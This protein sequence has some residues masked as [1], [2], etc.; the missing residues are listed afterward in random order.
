MKDSKLT[1]FD[2]GRIPAAAAAACSENISWFLRFNIWLLPPKTGT[3][4]ADA[5]ILA[6]AVENRPCYSNRKNI[7]PIIAKDNNIDWVIKDLLSIFY[8]YKIIQLLFETSLMRFFD[9]FI[10]ERGVSM[11]FHLSREEMSSRGAC[12]LEA[13]L[14]PATLTVFVRNFP[15]MFNFSRRALKFSRLVV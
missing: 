15:W 5:N 10:Q 2:C 1:N 9:W 4:T 12:W 11:F 14:T 13:A 3:A 7:Y 6:A 8:K